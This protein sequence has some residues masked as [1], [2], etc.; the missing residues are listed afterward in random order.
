MLFGKCE[1][2]LEQLQ[3]MLLQQEVGIQ[4]KMNDQCYEIE[5]GVGL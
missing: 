2:Q 4:E 1:R 3:P 5:Q